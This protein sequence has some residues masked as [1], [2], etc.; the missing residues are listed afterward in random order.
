[1]LAATITIRAGTLAVFP[2][3]P[4]VFQLDNEAFSGTPLSVLDV[5]T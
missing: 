1:M 2:L 4:L 5:I 3:K